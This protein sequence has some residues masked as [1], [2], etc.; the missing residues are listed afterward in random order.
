MTDQKTIE[1][2]VFYIAGTVAS[3]RGIGFKF[4]KLDR[5]YFEQNFSCEGKFSPA[6]YKNEDILM[7]M[8][9]DG[10]Q[11]SYENIVK[12]LKGESFSI[13]ENTYQFNVSTIA[14]TTPIHPKDWYQISVNEMKILKDLIG[15]VSWV[16]VKPENN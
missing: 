5:T 14:I 8:K 15:K 1:V 2:G 9:F 4:E 10:S 13:N 6:E 11:I 12:I 7:L 3:Q 16:Q